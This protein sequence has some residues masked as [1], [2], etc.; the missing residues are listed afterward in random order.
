MTRA[1]TA[2]G[3]LVVTASLGA[4][5]TA[6]PAP[7]EASFKAATLEALPGVDPGAIEI[8]NQ[9]QFPAKWTWDV[10]SSGKAYTCDAD[11][12]LRLPSCT[13]KV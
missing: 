12:L 2:L 8:S 7:T 6:A 9:K 11:N 13:P 10:Q 5:G 1:F 4:C 3:V